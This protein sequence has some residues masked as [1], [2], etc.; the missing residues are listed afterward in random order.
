[1]FCGDSVPRWCGHS[2]ICP[3]C[4]KQP[5]RQDKI[6]ALLVKQQHER[7]TEHGDKPHSIRRID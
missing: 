1:V 6:V 3:S 5:E 7:R 2:R 4:L